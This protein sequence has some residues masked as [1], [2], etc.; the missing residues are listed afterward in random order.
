MNWILLLLLG[1]LGFVGYEICKAPDASVTHKS[2]TLAPPPPLPQET[3]KAPEQVSQPASEPEKPKVDVE[4][5][6]NRLST[7]KLRLATITDALAGL[8]EKSIEATPAV[9]PEV[10]KSA[11]D[12]KHSIHDLQ[13]KIDS[14]KEQISGLDARAKSLANEIRSPNYV[15][16][17]QYVTRN[18]SPV[19]TTVHV[20]GQLIN[21]SV[22][23]QQVVQEQVRVL[24]TS[25]GVTV[26]G[27]VDQSN[28]LKGSLAA[29]RAKMAELNAAYDKLRVDT[30]TKLTKEFNS[31]M[32]EKSA[33]VK[34]IKENE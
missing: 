16:Q 4:A 2:I 6:K 5:S 18:V 22:Q 12:L 26:S 21:P 28:A 33:L 19:G 8:R 9:G 31:L 29:M 27:I 14:T 7:V 13:D 3:V 15:T 30:I 11:S 23:Q 20:N 1:I 34:T 10:L 25:R 24:D 17:T 32:V